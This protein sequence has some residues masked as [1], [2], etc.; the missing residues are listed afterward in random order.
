MRD[1]RHTGL[2]LFIHIPKTA[3]TTVRAALAEAYARD[4]RA[5]IYEPSVPEATTLEALAERPQVELDRLQL[6]MGHFDFGV[7][8]SLPG[9]ARY[10]SM[11]REPMDRLVSLFYY[12]KTGTFP[13]G[14][15]SARQHDRL[16][17]QDIPI[18]DYVF[19]A[20]HRQWDNQMVR[21][22]AGRMDVAFGRCED[23]MLREALDHVDEAFAAVLIRERMQASM[24][25]LER[26]CGRRLPGLA[27]APTREADRWRRRLARVRRLGR[28]QVEWWNETPNRE[29]VDEIEP[30]RLERL[31]ELN[32][33]DVE[34][35]RRMTQR[36][37]TSS[38]G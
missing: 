20:K 27:S 7:H 4:E 26:V 10:V 25:L 5:F 22:L 6:V 8:R 23:G 16:N 11:V 2:L 1:S 33:L 21:M 36:F 28:R 37:E 9:P 24:G 30:A 35:Y 19:D 13:P 14:T 17:A 31:R 12:F 29:T 18:D 3:G 15:G 32:R 38:G 34:L